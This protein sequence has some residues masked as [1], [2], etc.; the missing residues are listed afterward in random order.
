MVE[1]RVPG[2]SGERANG[3]VP[4]EVGFVVADVAH[5]PTYTPYSSDSDPM[6]WSIWLRELVLA[7]P[8]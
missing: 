2:T 6:R 4:A 3:Q 7:N 5:A 8:T 1:A